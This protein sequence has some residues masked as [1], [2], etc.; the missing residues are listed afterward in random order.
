M[1]GI[2]FCVYSTSYVFRH[3]LAQAISK[4]LSLKSESALWLVCHVETRTRLKLEWWQK[5]DLPIWW[6]TVSKKSISSEGSGSP[7]NTASE[8]NRTRISLAIGNCGSSTSN[9]EVGSSQVYRHPSFRETWT[10]SLNPTKEWR[11]RYQ[12]RTVSSEMENM[13]FSNK[14]YVEKVYQ[15]VQKELGRAPI[16][17]TF[18]VDSYRN[19]V[20]A[21]GLF[22]TSSMKAAIHLGRSFQDNSEIYKNMKFENIEN[23]FNITQKLMTEQVEEILI[24]KIWITSHPHGQDQHLATIKW[25]SRRRQK[26]VSTPTQFY[27]WVK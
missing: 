18:A 11:G 9:A 24:V 10:D 1:S 19:N 26:F 8:Y 17:S 16:N 14:P 3:I 25:L 20:L 23:V 27:A 7:V 6:C 5:S 15:C 4:V 2:T 12:H 22:M 21:W 13:I